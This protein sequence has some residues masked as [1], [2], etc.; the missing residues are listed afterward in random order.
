MLPVSPLPQ[1]DFPTITVGA[2]LP[3]ASAEIMASSV[4][5]PLERQF[6]H[7]AGVTEMTSSSALGTTT[8]TLQ[9]DLSRN[10][11]GA[12]RDVEAAINAAR[13]YLPAN[14]P[15]NP[16]YRKVNPADAPIM[17]LGLTSDIYGPGTAV[18]RSLHRHRAEA[19]A[20]PGRGPGHRRRRRAA[21]GARGGESHAAGQL[22]AHALRTLQSMLSLQ[23]ADLAKGQI[24]DGNVTA[25]IVANDQ[26][27]HAAD[28]KPLIV[29]YHNGAAVRLSDVADVMD[30]V[31]N[32][33]AAGYL[34]GKPAV[35]VIIFR[36]PGAN[37]IETVDRIR[38]QLPSL[39]ASIP[40]GID[41]TI[42]LDRTTT[43]RAS[44][45]DVERTLL[46]SIVPG[47]RGG[48][49]FPAQR[50]RHAD[51]RGRRAGFADRHLRGDVPVR[52]QPRQSLADGAD[53][54]HR[55]RGGRRHRG[56]GKHHA[57]H[58]ER[59][60]ALCGRAEGREGDR[61]HGLL[62]QHV[63]DR[64]LHSHAADGRNRRPAL[65]RIRDHAFD[66]HRR[67]DGDLA[68]HHADDVRAPAESERTKKHGRLYQCERT[69]LRRDAVVLS[70]QPALGAGQS[71]AHAVV[72]LLIIALN[73][74]VVVKIPKGFFPQQDTGAIVGGV[75]GPQDA[76]F[77]VMNDAV[78]Q[79][80]AR[81]QERPG[82]G[83]RVAFTGGRAPPT[84]ASSSSP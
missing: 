22:R 11:D 17:I 54:L 65:P 67:V 78:Q 5:T 73:V 81:D 33:R 30:S 79:I 9:F 59:H 56:D 14:L 7:I 10:I 31:Q 40:P 39:K 12:A 66:G 82:G 75:Q 42:V 80:G 69:V 70:A 43:I 19:L 23:N 83:E 2:G 16:T 35:M 4:A 53:H 20:D 61:L 21:V 8:I 1:V 24:S 52:L 6:G 32:V 64:R 72:L 84:P 62:D 47:D 68:D 26:I 48:V 27:S 37:I 13:T 71:G 38:A 55:I 44:V 49:R 28:Y 76:S 18:R 3:G 63:A 77:P 25:D 50:P 29:G 41:T 60:D 58:G 15:A 51:S 57:P 46:I 34:N 36:Q 74:V 45:N